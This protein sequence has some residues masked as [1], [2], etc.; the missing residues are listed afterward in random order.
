MP[1]KKTPAAKKAPAKKAAVKTAPKAAAKAAVKAPVK[2]ATKTA[3]KPAAKKVASKKAPADMDVRVAGTAAKPG[4]KG[5]VV[6][7]VGD[8]G[9]FGRTI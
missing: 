9:P 7:E 8:S 5:K 3:A 6:V 1:A 4:K 2:A